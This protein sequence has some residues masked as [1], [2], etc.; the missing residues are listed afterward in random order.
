MGE[1]RQQELP[2][3]LRVE[4]APASPENEA[5]LFFVVFVPVD[6]AFAP[7]HHEE[8]V[9]GEVRKLPVHGSLGT[10]HLAI[11]NCI[12]DDK[13]RGMCNNI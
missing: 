1:E 10:I 13:Y 6:Q 2:G 5:H 3:G 9:E 4:C 8:A 7:A 11:S 12:A